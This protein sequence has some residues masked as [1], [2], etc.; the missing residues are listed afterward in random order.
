MTAL[1]DIKVLETGSMLAGPFCGTLLGDFGAEVIKLEKPGKP[2]ALREWPPFKDGQ[3]LWWKAM[4]RNK[5]LATLDISRPEARDATLALIGRSDI[6]IENFR[7]GTLERWGL[8]PANLAAEFPHIVWVRVS[9]Y[10]QTGPYSGRGGYATIAEAYSGLASFTGF[11]DRGPMVSAFPLGDYVAG[12]YA[13]FGA[14]AAINARRQTGRGQVVD[15]SLF[16]PFLRIL[17]S[18]IVRYDQTGRKKP[19]LGNQMEEDVPRNIYATRDGHV[20]ISVGSQAIFNNLLDAMG[21][22]DLKGDKRFSSQDARAEN[23]DATDGLVRDWLAQRTTAEALKAFETNK[24]VA[25]KINDMEDVFA[26]PHMAARE[27]LTTVMDPQFGPMRLPA[28]VP[29]LSETP[30]QVRWTGGEPGRDNDHVFRELLG[31]SVQ[32]IDGMRKAGV[33]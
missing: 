25:G 4:A 30:G 2:D 18:A 29:K 33:I 28:P 13:A 20:A 32:T 10:G 9:G 23:R 12:T 3:P 26:D 27:A 5:R 6:V 14:M 8:G 17:E 19:L 11:P 21:R 15:V 24:V 31:L 1:S 16:E 22:A 7:P